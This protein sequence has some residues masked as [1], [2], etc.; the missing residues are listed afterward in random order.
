MAKDNE[1]E[2]IY[3]CVCECLRVYK[4]INKYMY[5]YIYIY[6]ML[7]VIVINKMCSISVIEHI[8]AKY[9]VHREN[10]D[11][12]PIKSSDKELAG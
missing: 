11:F 2:I 1:A 7:F 4:Y 3:V 9:C 8:R 10:G 5:T 12:L 6:I